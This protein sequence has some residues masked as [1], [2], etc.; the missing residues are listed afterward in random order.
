MQQPY[1]W[2][3]EAQLATNIDHISEHFSQGIQGILHRRQA[4][5]LHYYLNIIDKNKPC[6]VISPGRGEGYLKYQE[7][8]FDLTNNGFNVAILDHRGQGLSDREQQQRHR[9]YVLSFDHYVE[10]LHEFIESEVTRRCEGSIFLLGHSMG[11]TIASL[12]VQKYPQHI[13]ALALSAPM[14][15]LDTGS[16]PH[17]LATSLVATGHNINQLFSD[18]AWYFF[19]HGPYKEKPFADN[20][21]THSRIRYQTFRDTWAEHPKVQLGGVTFAWLNAAIDG[22]EKVFRQL[23]LQKTPTL[24]IQAEQDTVVDNR[25]QD[26]FCQQHLQLT[27]QGC[28]PQRPLVIGEARHEILFESDPAREQALTAIVNFFNAHLLQTLRPQGPGG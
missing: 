6:I 3:K 27:G 28:E 2:S 16:L 23:P 1:S 8:V 19:G 20:D 7:L 13:Q 15:G 5:D 17:W 4:P 12:Y 22:M 21:L 18:Q 11:G 14:F 10:D 26:R 9:G 25:A 24:L